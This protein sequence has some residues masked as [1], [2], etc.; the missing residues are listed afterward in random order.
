MGDVVTL[1]VRDV[2]VGFEAPV[3]VPECGAGFRLTAMRQQVS[4]V[5]GTLTVESEA[6]VGTAISSRVPSA[7]D[8][9]ETE[10]L[11]L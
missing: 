6:G 8:R 4:R 10:A 2:G 9:Q 1:D 5:T 7:P 11:E 3:G